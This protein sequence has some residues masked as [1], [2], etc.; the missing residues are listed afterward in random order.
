MS[1]PKLVQN[2]P[3][4]LHRPQR[5]WCWLNAFQDGDG[6]ITS[7]RCL[8]QTRAATMIGVNKRMQNRVAEAVRENADIKTS[9]QAVRH[10]LKTVGTDIVRHVDHLEE[11]GLIGF[12]VTFALYLIMFICW[13]RARSSSTAIPTTIESDNRPSPALHRSQRFSSVYYVVSSHLELLSIKVLTL[14]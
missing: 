11:G 13:Y 1:P 12:C 8:N 4:S 5:V 14:S 6:K 10:V 7:T 9:V 2:T 3:F